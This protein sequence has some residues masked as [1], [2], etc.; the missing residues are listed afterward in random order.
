MRIE[1]EKMNGAGNDFVMIDNLGGDIHLSA[2][3][4]RRLCDRRRG[5]GADGVILLEEDSGAD[6]RM[7]YYNSDGGEV[8]MCGNGARCAALFAVS[9]GLGRS[10]E[11]RTVLRF[12]AEPGLMEAAVDGPRVAIGM[13]DATAFEKDISLPVAQGS[14][15]VHVINTGVPH[16]VVVEPHAS[17]MSDREVFE[18]GRAIRYHARFAPA[19]ANANFVTVGDDGAVAIRT[20]ERGVEEETLACGTGAVASAVVTAHLNELPSPVRLTTHGGEELTVSFDLEPAG[21]RN[22]VLEGPATVNFSGTIELG[23]ET[24]DGA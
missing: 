6:Y 1:F 18:R 12:T 23:E 16:V 3:H 5:I 2:S 17:T 9:L 7:R 15:I 4:I 8:E 11:G 20:Y 14:E 13:T 10:Q 21:A 24:S 19:G 22:V